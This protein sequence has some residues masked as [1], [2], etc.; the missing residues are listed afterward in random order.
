MIVIL[1]SLLL[2]VLAVELAIRLPFGPALRSVVTR[3]RRAL[4]V[5]RSPAISDHWKERA[6]L[7]YAR[8]SL[9]ESLRLLVYVLFLAGAYAA[10]VL[11]VDW[12]GGKLGAFLLS[13]HGMGITLVASAL[14]ALARWRFG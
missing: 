12:L 8:G 3:N 2:S 1:G 9:Q 4:H 7:G 14:Y 5:I 13:P 11:V 10:P 6:L